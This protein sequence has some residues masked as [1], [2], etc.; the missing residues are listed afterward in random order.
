MLSSA[1]HISHPVTPR[2][3]LTVHYISPLLERQLIL[4][5]KLRI[6]GTEQVDFLP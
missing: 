3:R 2:V 4:E 5:L 6:P 1:A